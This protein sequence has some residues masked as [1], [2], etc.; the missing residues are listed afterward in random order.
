MGNY[1]ILEDRVEMKASGLGSTCILCSGFLFL[2]SSWVREAIRLCAGGDTRAVSWFGGADF[3]SIF[4]SLL[5]VVVYC[6]YCAGNWV[7]WRLSPHSIFHPPVAL[8]RGKS[9]G[10]RI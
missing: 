7:G 9:R 8:P 5:G 4:H 6:N 1:D 3:P 10:A 2:F